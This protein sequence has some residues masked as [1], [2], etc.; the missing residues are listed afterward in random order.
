MDSDYKK[1]PLDKIKHCHE[2]VREL[3]VDAGIKQLATSIKDMG[4]MQPI[5]IYLN[6]KTN[7]YCVLSGHRRLVAYGYLNEKFPDDE[8]GKI[9][10]H[11]IPEP[12]KKF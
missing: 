6:S 1:I 4:L 10:S 7:F 12:E 9:F 3:T 5:I 2:G 11:I 8:Y